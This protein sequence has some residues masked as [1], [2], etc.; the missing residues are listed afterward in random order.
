MK[1]LFY[2]ESETINLIV[3][4]L[5]FSRGR[6]RRLAEIFRLYI[7]VNK[8]NYINRYMYTYRVLPIE[9]L[10]CVVCVTCTASETLRTPDSTQTHSVLTVKTRPATPLGAVSLTVLYSPISIVN[11]DWFPLYYKNI[12]RRELDWFKILYRNL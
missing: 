7:D 6:D 5:K 9:P 10:P 4:N 11:L 3:N 12:V 2:Q 8:E 1:L